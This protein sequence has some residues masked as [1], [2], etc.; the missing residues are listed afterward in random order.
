MTDTLTVKIFF[1]ILSNHSGH[2][3]VLKKIKQMRT[4]GLLLLMSVLVSCEDD[5]FII[6]ED[7]NDTVV[8]EGV[9]FRSSPTAKYMTSDVSISF[10]QNTFIGTSSED[11][12]PAICE[13]TFTINN[14]IIDFENS[15]VWTADFDWTLILSGK[16]F[17][18]GDQEGLTLVKRQGDIT[19][20]Y[21]LKQK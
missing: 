21:I 20:T 1:Y 3:C 17:I 15:C 7:Y 12:Y 18:D 5:G 19:D 11:K 13:G 4:F 8:F 6:S 14:G 9:F 16:W 10:K 2:R